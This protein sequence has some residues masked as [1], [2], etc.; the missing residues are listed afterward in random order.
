MFLFRRATLWLGCALLLVVFVAAEDFAGGTTYRPLY[1]A[2]P[3]EAAAGEEEA[4][5]VAEITEPAHAGAADAQS[6]LVEFEPITVA[7]A[8]SELTE[9]NSKTTDSG[10]ELELQALVILA[11]DAISPDE[12]TDGMPD[13]EPTPSI[14]PALE[15]DVIEAIE[16]APAGSGDPDVAGETAPNE[17]PD[18]DE[19]L[20]DYVFDLDELDAP[21]IA[22]QSFEEPQGPTGVAA[23]RTYQRVYRVTA[24]CDRGTTAAG[25][26]AGAGQCAAPAN[27]PFGSKI[28]V[29][30]LNRTFIVT[31]RTHRRFRH[32]T[33]DLFIPSRAD[34][35]KFGRKYLTCEIYV[36]AD[37]PRYG[38]VEVA[39]V[40]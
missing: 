6:D 28:Y 2:S 5:D 24:Y 34:C 13:N 16:T 18:E 36:P 3:I 31:D 38:E 17:V 39:A 11:A 19:N 8:E 9:A 1:S 23:N 22:F 35:L 33:V 7:A 30:A 26:R 12:A 10:G 27:I 29:P 37:P 21:D 15:M 32:N 40:R 14:E 4:A 25:T 20:S